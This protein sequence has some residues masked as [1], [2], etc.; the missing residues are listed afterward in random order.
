M[1][2][3]RNPQGGLT[4]FD[5]QPALWTAFNAYYGTLWSDGIVDDPT[6]P[7]FIFCRK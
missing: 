1:A 3:V 7:S 4:P 5:H 6:S 2:R